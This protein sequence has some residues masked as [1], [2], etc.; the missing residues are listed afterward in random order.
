M[1]VGRNVCNFSKPAIFAGNGDVACAPKNRMRLANVL[2]APRRLSSKVVSLVKAVNDRMAAHLSKNAS[3]IAFGRK[4]G[5]KINHSSLL[6]R[7][8]AIKSA[9]RKLGA[10]PN[11]IT[12]QR[13]TLLAGGTA[14]TRS[15]FCMSGKM[16]FALGACAL[17]AAKNF[18]SITTL[19][20]HAVAQTTSPTFDC[21]TQSAIFR[22]AR[23]TL[24]T[25]GCNT[26]SLAG[27]C[28]TPLTGSVA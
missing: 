15:N 8:C 23:K 16:A 6:L 11:V 21:C 12:E 24:Y 22:K 9:T 13:N 3:A 25:S 10:S 14:L 20:C 2:S 1:I 7:C 28:R 27:D 19:R 5:A 17:L 18:M 4:N 26:V